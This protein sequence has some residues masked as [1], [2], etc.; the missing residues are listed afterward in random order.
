MGAGREA[1]V[2]A[3]L[4]ANADVNLEANEYLAEREPANDGQQM[5]DKK[6]RTPLMVCLSPARVHLF[7]SCV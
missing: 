3:L 5:K 2:G 1:E 7:T 6:K 4:A